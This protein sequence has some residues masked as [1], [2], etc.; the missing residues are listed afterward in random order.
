VKIDEVLVVNLNTF[1][2]SFPSLTSV[3]LEGM[4]IGEHLLECDSFSSAKEIMLPFNGLYPEICMNFKHILTFEKLEVFDIS[5]NWA[6]F[7]GLVHL[8]ESLLKTT[9]L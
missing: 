8:K 6:M 3:Y 5:Q 7:G 1:L 2:K 4:K 9:C